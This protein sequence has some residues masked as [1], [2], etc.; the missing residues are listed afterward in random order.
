MAINIATV[1]SDLEHLSVDIHL[2]GLNPNTHYDLLRLEMAHAGPDANGNPIYERQ[3]PD[4]RKYWSAVAHRIGWAPATA[5]PIVHDYECPRR[6]TKYFIVESALVGPTDFDF[7][8]GNYP[9]A[10]GFLD[11]AVVDF[12]YDLYHYDAV[13]PGDLIVRSTH[14]LGK[15]AGGLHPGPATPGLQG[16]GQRVRGDGQPVPGLR[17]RHPGGRPGHGH[18]GLPQPRRLSSSCTRSS[19]LQWPDQADH[20]PRLGP[21]GC[22]CTTS[23]WCRWT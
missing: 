5:N 23:G 8:D 9:V 16:P 20:L 10:R 6:P 4:R 13:P 1:K 15:H 11:N 22:C 7:T 14:E 3:I 18:P 21:R 2:T 19:S 12:N 17:L